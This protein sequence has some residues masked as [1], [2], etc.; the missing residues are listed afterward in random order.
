MV[1]AAVDVDTA[2]IVVGG[3]IV[4][5]D[6]DILLLS[7]LILLLLLLLLPVCVNTDVHTLFSNGLSLPNDT[8][9]GLSEHGD[10][11]RETVSES[12]SL[13]VGPFKNTKKNI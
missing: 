6:N 2:A 7:L 11:S 3:V 8:G 1:V 4:V 9:L 10:V 13:N 5:D 12:S